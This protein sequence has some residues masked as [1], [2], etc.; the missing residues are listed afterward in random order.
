[1]TLTQVDRWHRALMTARPELGHATTVRDTSDAELLDH[2]ESGLMLVPPLP[3]RLDFLDVEGVLARISN[4]AHPLANMVTHARLTEADADGSLDRVLDIYA[5]ANKPVLWVVGPL[6]TPAD[7]V[8]RLT[9]RGFESEGELDALVLRNLATEIRVNP[10]IEVREVAPDAMSPFSG[11]L[12]SS[13]GLQEEMGV[14]V[15]DAYAAVRSFRIRPYVAFVRDEPVSWGTSIYVPDTS[16]LLLAGAATAPEHRSKG[17]YS[18]LVARRL[19]D[20]RADGMD[21]AL[22]Q[23]VHT[24][25]SPICR[26]LG[27]EQIG[28][29]EVLVGQAPATA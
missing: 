23:A 3:G 8:S 13:Y 14:L 20:A 16:L 29:L 17:I 6:S 11:M 19:A 25:S 7:L 4:I 22:I 15:T 12:A 28:S 5:R 18:T 2:A 9:D 10:E 21:T 26:G 1:M 27:F 24:T